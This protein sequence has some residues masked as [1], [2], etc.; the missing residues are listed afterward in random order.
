VVEHVKSDRSV[1]VFGASGHT[2]RFVVA[3]LLRRGFSPVAIGRDAARLEGF[4]DVGIEIKT[5]ST[6]N[7]E[8]LDRALAGVRAVINCA[9][10]FLDTADQLVEAAL[11]AR[12]HY[13]DVTAEQASALATFEQFGVLSAK[14]GIVV[15]PA[16]GFYGGLADILATA[17]MGNWTSADE[18]RIAIA[19]D[20]WRPTLGTRLTGERN[21][22]QRVV[23]ANGR[24]VPLA[25]PA[26]TASWTFPEPFGTQDVLEVPLTE[27][28]LI[29][30]HLHVSQVHNYLN[31]APL[32]DL[33][34]AATPAPTPA[35]ESGRSAQTFLVDV[36]VRSGAV[37]RRA[38]VRGRDIYAVTAPLVVE[39]TQRIVNGTV[40][41]GGVFAPG[42][43]FDARNFLQALA[44]KH[45]VIESLNSLPLRKASR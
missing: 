16:M 29:N 30:R 37:A 41:T 1:A 3:E 11:R 33:G 25:D 34:D 8:S 42:A 27:M 39:A 9:G 6:D 44:P 18:I 21:T 12:I 35:D 20:S 45:L 26:P 5:A 24:L 43:I 36:V 10:P 15:V 40:P 7:R 4:R 19:L 17:A 13:L 22:A 23:V 31:L 28:I 32:R 14:A 38:T 2:G